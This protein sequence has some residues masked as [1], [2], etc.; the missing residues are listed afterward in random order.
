MP[1]VSSQ[2]CNIGPSGSIFVVT[3]DEISQLCFT[4]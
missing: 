2:T 1:S 4:E 3:H